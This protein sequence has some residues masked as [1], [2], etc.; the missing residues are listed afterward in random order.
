MTKDNKILGTFVLDGIP[1]APKT[2]PQIEV[3][4][5]IDVNGILNVSAEE[6][7]TR[8][9]KGITIICKD[10]LSSDEIER[11]K[12][13]AEKLTEMDKLIKMKTYANDELE[14]Y[15]FWLKN[16]VDDEKMK[17]DELSICIGSKLTTAIAENIAWMD[18]NPDAETEGFKRKRQDLENKM[19]R[20]CSLCPCE[21]SVKN[22]PRRPSA[23]RS[24]VKVDSQGGDILGGEERFRAK[25]YLEY[26]ANSIKKKFGD[27][28]K[29]GGKFTEAEIQT[30]KTAVDKQLQWLKNNPSAETEHYERRIADLERVVDSLTR[31]VVNVQNWY[32]YLPVVGNF[33][34][35]RNAHPTR[36]KEQDNIK[37]KIR[38]RNDLQ[39]YAASVKHQTKTLR[40]KVEMHLKWLLLHENANPQE[41]AER[42]L[43]LEMSVQLVVNTLNEGS[44]DWQLLEEKIGD[45]DHTPLW[46]R[47][48]QG[49]VIIIFI[50]VTCRW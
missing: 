13:K 9:R 10:R 43:E 26:Y 3:T 4:F 35:A 32:D 45:N 25:N 22:T 49:V 36:N 5:V 17:G 1:M 2:H 29:L 47:V 23:E 6:K 42:I 50:I 18:A 44:L 38:L 28:K 46:R 34:R 12:C 21:E 27:M 39:S 48:L 11:M 16:R 14:S 37:K 40:N 15:T 20:V 24:S 30:V 7:R 31:N 8:K 33:L 41:Y 19:Q